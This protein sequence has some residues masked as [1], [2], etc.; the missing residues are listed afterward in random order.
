MKVIKI[1]ILGLAGLLVLAALV[2]MFG[3]PAQPLVAFLNDQAQKAGYQL[4]VEG[5]AKISLFS[6][7]NLSADDIRLVDLKHAREEVLTAKQVR[8]GISLI[9]LLTGNVEVDE[10]NVIKPV[11]RL[12]G[13]RK[14]E[15]GGRAASPSDDGAKR[16]VAIGRLTIEDGTLILRDLR[17]N[18]EDHITGIQMTASLPAQ[19]PLDVSGEGKVGE[20]LVRFTGKASSVSQIADGK[21]TP[22]EGKLELP[23]FLKE[24]LSISAN[25]KSSNQ[26]V[27]V[28]G[29]RGTLGSGRVNGSFSVDAS[30]EN[31]YV[32]INLVFDRLEIVGGDSRTAVGSETW[33]DKPIEFGGLRVIELAIKISARE[34]VVRNIQ[35]APAEV[36]ANLNRGLLSIS[37]SRSDLYGG[38]IQA[39]FVLDAATRSGR[40][41]ASFEFAR[42]SALPFFTD[43]LG[44]DHVEGRLQAKLDLTGTGASP[45]EIVSS[46]GGTASMSIEDGAI[47]DVNVPAMVR[48]LSNQTLQGWQDKGTE[49]TDFT[50]L[51]ATFRIANGQ[52][53]TDDLRLSGPLVRM[54][55]KGAVNLP[56]RTLDF[57]VDPKLVLSLQGQGGPNDPAGLGVPVAVRGTWSEPRIYPDIA[58]I[59][60]N[61]DAAFAKLKSMGGSLFGLLDS[62]GSGKRPKA[63]EV[64]KSLD[65]MIR[66]D[67]RGRQSP[68]DPANQVRDAIRDLLGR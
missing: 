10:V 43:A 30:A 54:T 53:T 57:R 60:D 19:G 39:K 24:A 58:G 61:P 31:P 64:I 18:L 8:V 47:R 2:L 38:P 33:S 4:S 22:I 35:L 56:A 48:A 51:T 50:S 63:E 65:Q 17:E 32:T 3:I 66:G 13:G 67:G 15:S 14:P 26:I 6:S 29:V 37:L 45:Y 20:Q 21:S 7:L 59:L 46:L 16:N 25:L 49:K 28:D 34:L 52:A 12:T 5:P 42:V 36:E 11:I 27:S 1:T 23:G 40:L 68:S 55:G 44:F 41:G 62:S 9:G